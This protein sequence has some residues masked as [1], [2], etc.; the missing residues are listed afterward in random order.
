MMNF[1][2]F[3]VIGANTL[4]MIMLRVENVNASLQT[5]L[6]L[7]TIGYTIVRTINEIRKLKNKKYGEAD[8]GVSSQD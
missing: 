8:S 6:I 5:I 3:K 2:D 1:D 7:L 4:C